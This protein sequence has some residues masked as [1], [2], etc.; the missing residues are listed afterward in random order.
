M[1]VLSSLSRVVPVLSLSL[2]AAATVSWGV[3]SYAPA[4]PD[5]VTDRKANPNGR[6]MIVMYHSIGPVDKYMFRSKEGFRNDLKRLYD[7]GYRPVTFSDYLDGKFDIPSGASPVVIT[8]DDSRESQFSYRKDG[9]VD[10]DCAVGVWQEFAK[11]HPDFPVKGTFF[12]LPNGPFGSNKT[13]K[14]KVKAL[15]S[16]GCELASHTMSHTFLDRLDDAEVKSELARSMDWLKGLG[17]KPRVLALPY[18]VAPK[19]PALLRGFKWKGKTYR[20]QAVALAGSSP[21][22]AST[23]PKANPYAVPRVEGSQAEGGL[24]GWLDK[25]AKGKSAPLVVP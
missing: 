12:I 25:V 23:D 14:Q 4:R 1:T 7:M 22:R 21:A 2:L 9:S 6:V 11:S 16:W 15:L 17:A 19:N 10:P 20:Y 18:G 24:R 13:G 3:P 5:R 8:F